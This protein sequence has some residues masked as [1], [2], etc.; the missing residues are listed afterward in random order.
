MQ[1]KKTFIKY[2]GLN[3]YIY[4]VY[5]LINNIISANSKPISTLKKEPPRIAK[6]STRVKPKEHSSIAHS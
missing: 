4:I 3:S 6:E 1:K 2:L 5:M